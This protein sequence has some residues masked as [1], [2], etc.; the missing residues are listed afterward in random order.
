MR[1]ALIAGAALAVGVAIGWGFGSAGEAQRAQTL[2][3]ET[4]TARD[5]HAAAERR[6]ADL[7]DAA[8]RTRRR[9]PAERD[10]ASTA[11][12]PT[13]EAS[14]A[15]EA[16]T[17]ETDA[18][19]AETD[20]PTSAERR[21][22]VEALRADVAQWFDTG[23]GD[24]AVAALKE[25]AAL[26]PEGR[27]EAM[28]LALKI[29]TDVNGRGVLGLS[30]Q[31]FYAG[32]GDPGVRELMA[33]SLSPES[34][35]ESPAKFRVMA[36]YSLPWT[37]PAEKTVSQFVTALK[38]EGDVRVQRALVANL[39][40]MR[41]PEANEVLEQLFVD[42]GRDPVLRS[43]IV[44]ELALGDDV[45]VLRLIEQAAEN[46]A[47]ERVR[48]AAKAALVARDPPASGFLVT[49]TLPASQAE[50]AGLRAGDIVVSYAGQQ[51]LGVE[52][53]RRAAAGS[54]GEDAVSVVVVRGGREVTLLCRPGQL[55]VY[56]R[57]VESDSQ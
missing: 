22:R 51:T 2:R 37:Q 38:E 32:L 24:A 12:Q 29:N 27:R 45:R 36:A 57:D 48:E 34:E 15:A 28:A 54:G 31:A 20:A 16:P 21:R 5:A 26:T 56:G 17:A 14:G 30:I 11:R 43:Q 40:S 25:L 3:S 41:R 13:A 10:A 8:R 39:S 53:L 50:A 6:I 52:A 47:D 18:A 9:A 19:V 42:G 23:D 4:A 7:E 33:W 49:G 1:Q 35:S 46:D 55:G 44:T